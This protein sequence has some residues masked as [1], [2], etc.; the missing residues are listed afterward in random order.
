MAPTC[1]PPWVPTF[2]PTPHWYESK[3]KLQAHYI[4]EAHMYNAKLENE[5]GELVDR[6]DVVRGHARELARENR[7]L[8]VENRAL[9]REVLEGRVERRVLRGR[10]GVLKGRIGVLRE[11]GGGLRE[12]RVVRWGRRVERENL[13]LKGRI[14]VLERRLGGEGG[15]GGEGEVVG[16]VE[17]VGEGG[18]VVVAEDGGEVGDN[19]DVEDAVKKAVP[20][21]EVLT[22]LHKQW[23]I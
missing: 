18:D 5:I 12:L 3:I 2:P 4:Q 1:P 8:G 15:G 23:G 17:V 11:R 21:T 20:L 9:E 10:I 22:A 13:G 19:E 7:A 16:E 14:E 6:V